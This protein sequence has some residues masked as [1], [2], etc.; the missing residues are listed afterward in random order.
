MVCYSAVYSIVTILVAIVYS[1]RVSKLNR[2]MATEKEY[3]GGKGHIVSI[4]LS[5]GHSISIF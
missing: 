5:W 3:S 4:S 2:P 1:R